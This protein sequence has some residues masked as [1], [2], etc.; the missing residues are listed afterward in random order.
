MVLKKMKTKHGKTQKL[1][2]YN[3][4]EITDELYIV[5]E[6]CVKGREGEIAN[7]NNLPRI[8][9]AGL[10]DY[11]E[12]AEMMQQHYKITDTAYSVREG[13]STKLLRYA[14]NYWIKL[15]SCKKMEI[16]SNTIRLLKGIFDKG[17][18]VFQSHGFVFEVGYYSF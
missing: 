10:L 6:Y 9:F 12:K 4:L 14:K 11:K 1:F 17:V 5:R 2:L 8:I 18:C 15:K 3:E 13:F 7:S 16:I